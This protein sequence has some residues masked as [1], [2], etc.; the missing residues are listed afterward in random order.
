MIHSRK[1]KIISDIQE[2][3]NSVHENL[4]KRELLN[5]EST[6]DEWKSKELTSLYYPDQSWEIF[7]TLFV[8][9]YS[10]IQFKREYEVDPSD[11]ILPLDQA[12]EEHV[13]FDIE[14][15]IDD[16]YS[17]IEEEQDRRTWLIIFSQ[18][19]IKTTKKADMKI[20]GRI[21]KAISKICLSPTTVRGDTVRPL[22]REKS[23][24]WRYRIGDYRLIYKPDIENNHIVLLSFESRGSVY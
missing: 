3:L 19:F 15:G 22:S 5:I 9:E 23:G 13:E 20:Q 8:D 16:L 2:D 21:L 11:R 10:L 18:I 6:I 12:R 14:P 17:E 7:K 24:L 4:S 1:E